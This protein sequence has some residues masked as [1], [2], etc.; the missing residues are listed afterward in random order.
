MYSLL[1]DI[2][3]SLT[4]C[5]TKILHPSIITPKELFLE[6][7]KIEPYFKDELP[8]DLTTKHI[9]DFEDILD[10]NCYVEQSNIIYLLSIPI[11]YKSNFQLYYLHSIPSFIDTNII[12]IIP[13]NKYM[14]KSDNVIKPLNYNCKEGKYY[15]C[16]IHSLSNND[17]SCEKEILKVQKTDKCEYVKI[18]MSHNKVEF[19]PSINQYL[20]IFP[21]K[22]SLTFECEK[23]IE[24]ENLEGVFLIEHEPCKVL[25]KNEQ[26][27]FNKYSTGKPLVLKNIDLAHS[28]TTKMIQSLDL[29]QTPINSKSTE[30]E[31]YF[32][33]STFNY[34]IIYCIVIIILSIYYYKK[35][36]R[37]ANFNVNN[38]VVLS[39]V[40]AKTSDPGVSKIQ[41]PG[42]AQF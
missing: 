3:N 40:E 16:P 5:K 42:D 27:P 21:Q 18:T 31:F 17:A 1:Q 34:L 30:D 15:Q 24:T 39:Q 4:F 38:Q 28:R 19:I 26:L 36:T 33:F 22:D 32:W 25:Y 9:P 2:E 29:N 37:K 14:L 10:I 20:T 6:L 35:K 12:T 7:K 8:F 23:N 41:L 11:N 13:T